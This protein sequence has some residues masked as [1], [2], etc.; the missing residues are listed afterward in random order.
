MAIEKDI[1]KWDYFIM[2]AAVADF[3]I[4]NDTSKKIP[5]SKFKEY[6]FGLKLS[7]RLGKKAIHHDGVTFGFHSQTLRFPDDRLTI[8]ILSNNGNFR[9]DLMA[10]E[11]ASLFMR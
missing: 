5:K 2:N 4:T 10:D 11:I 1:F 7:A 8:F 3:K 6:G 9:S